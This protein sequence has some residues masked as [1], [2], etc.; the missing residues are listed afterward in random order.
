MIGKRVMVT[1]LAAMMPLCAIHGADQKGLESLRGAVAIEND[2]QMPQ[3]L[4]EKT[5]RTPV[6]RNFPQQPPLIPHP[7]KAY[8]INLKQNKCLSCHAADKVEESGAVPVGQSHY[9]DRDGNVLPEVSA[10]RYFCNQCHVEQF[11][12][13]PLVEN[14]FR[15]ATPSN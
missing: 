14:D 13:T 7:T 10:G 1:A 3:N 9:R 15:P 6:A 2:S 4:L 8:R 12:V 11:T 5:D